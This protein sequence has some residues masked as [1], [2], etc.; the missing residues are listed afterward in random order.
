ML[1][2]QVLLFGTLVFFSNIFD[3]QLVES[4]DVE[5]QVTEELTV[6]L[7]LDSSKD[8]RLPAIIFP[9]HSFCLFHNLKGI[10][11]SV[12]SFYVIPESKHLFLFV[13]A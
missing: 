12:F 6:F 8:S 3:P 7:F 11:V 2:T 5:T 13:S 4:A 1:Q 9:E 10:L